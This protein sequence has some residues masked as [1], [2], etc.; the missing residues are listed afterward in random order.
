MEI[1]VVTTYEVTHIIKE[2]EYPGF[3]ETGIIASNETAAQD[4]AKLLGKM[5]G[6]DSSTV[7]KQQFFVTDDN[8]TES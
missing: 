5:L 4:V 1:T 6:A 3:D 2:S 8:E 7:A